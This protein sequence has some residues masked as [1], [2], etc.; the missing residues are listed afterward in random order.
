M[1]TVKTHSR[2]A[3]SIGGRLALGL[4]LAAAAGTMAAGPALGEENHRQGQQ[5]ARGH[6]R[7]G[8]EMDRRAGGYRHGYQPRGYGYGYG[9]PVIYAPP[10]VVY[11]PVPSP[12]ISL[13]I[14]F[15]FR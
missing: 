1:N 15:S 9:G 5:Q 2:T 13:V 14:P 7:D 8:H 6:E 4:A 12:G 11:G 3:G 10:P